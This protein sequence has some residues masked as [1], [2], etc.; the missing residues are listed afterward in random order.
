MFLGRVLLFTIPGCPFCTRAKKLLSD[1]QVPY[2]AVCLE[3]FPERRYEMQ[4][5]TGRRSVP[6]IFFNAKHIGGYD[7]MKKLHDEGKLEDLLKEVASTDVP[8][9]AP[10][11]PPE[12]IDSEDNL[13][14]L[15]SQRDG[16]NAS[17]C[18]TNDCTPDE[19]AALVREMRDSS[20]LIRAHTYHLVTYKNCFIGKDFV[21]WLVEK[22]GLSS[23]EEAVKF[24]LELQQKQFFH[25][26]TFDHE[27]KDNS[28]FYRLLGD[29]YTRALNA[30][31]SF[32][33][34]PRPAVDV[35]KD[36]RRYI[37]EI[38]DDF[39]T[40]DG[41]AVDYR[42]ISASKKFER[43]V[44]ATAELKRVDLSSLSREEKLAFFINMYNALVIHAF[45]V[46]GPPNNMWKRFRF[47]NV[48][49]YII[50]GRVYTLND[51][52]SGILRANRK[53]V[54]AFKRP[55]SKDDPRLKVMLDECEPLIH[56]ALVCGAKSCPPIKTY[57]AQRINEELKVAGESFM[58]GEALLV[59]TA[60]RE[61]S[62]TMIMKWYRVDFG[63]SNQE[64]IQFVIDH[65]PDCSKKEQLRTMTQ[66]PGKEIKIKFQT[67][68]WGLN[69]T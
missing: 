43:Y 50:G 12:D 11:P 13:E 1:L 26:V 15:P 17:E 57:S 66:E 42:G 6:Q 33:C 62:V 67:Y 44:H 35:A 55:F 65:L 60:K 54:G 49:S 51:I 9:D 58:E 25:H 14:L 21:T 2:V 7:D 10:A 52:E 18:L 45:V 27:F 48:V 31:L 24:G 46:Q 23:R 5:R 3:K 30:Q 20:G 47:F 4:E 16:A 40:A 38:Y 63:S 37:V 64:L 39:L 59:D 41:A 69:S 29:G 53:P 56:F 28:L 36:L 61:I 22:K 19:L 8:A 68:N 34:I 32:A